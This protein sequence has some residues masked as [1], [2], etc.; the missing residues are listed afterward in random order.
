MIVTWLCVLFCAACYV[1]LWK[2]LFPRAHPR[3]V[4][5]AVLADIP[6]VTFRGGLI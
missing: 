4:P 2:M 3:Y 5:P 1:P 6:N